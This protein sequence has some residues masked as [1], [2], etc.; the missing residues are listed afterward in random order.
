VRLEVQT[1]NWR[2]APCSCSLTVDCRAVRSVG[3]LAKTINL[4]NNR[5]KPR[6]IDTG[7]GVDRSARPIGHND[8]SVLY[9]CPVRISC[10]KWATLTE[11]F[12]DIPQ[13]FQAGDGLN[14]GRNIVLPCP[15]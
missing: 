11:I 15:Y 9:R 4:E 13:Y 7:K 14:F 12:R 8:C 1:L 6:I 2:E 10:N 3:A 5:R